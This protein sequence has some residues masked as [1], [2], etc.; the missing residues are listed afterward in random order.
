MMVSFVILGLLVHGAYW[1]G[2]AVRNYFNISDEK[3]ISYKC[4]QEPGQTEHEKGQLNG[5]SN[6]NKHSSALYAPALE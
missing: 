4:F 2:P 1:P 3:A 6:K 5:T